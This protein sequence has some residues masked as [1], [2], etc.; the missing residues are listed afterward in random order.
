MHY[1]RLNAETRMD[2][3]PM[4]RVDDI[5]DQVGQAKYL[6]TLDLANGYWQVPVVVEDRPKTAFVTPQG[7]YQFCVMPFG[8]C[9]A[10]AT[11]QRMMD[12]VTQGMGKFTS[13]YLD[14]LIVFSKTWEDHLVH[15][16]TVLS[17]L[18]TLGL[19]ANSSKCQFAMTECIYLGHIVGN[20]VVKPER[21][22]LLAV[23]QFPLP[24]TKTQVRSFLGLLGYYRRFIPNYA[25]IAAPLTDLTR[26]SAPEN[27]SLGIEGVKSFSRLKE[28]M[29]SSAVLR[30]PDFTK[31]FILQ[32][33]ASEVGV[34]ANLS[35]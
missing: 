3:Y 26:K 21:G 24:T 12:H 6:S 29:L 5:L 1:R 20:G 35:Q 10:P 17:R 23:T 31:P 25:T 8:L 15:L 4:P 11:F 18:Q 22:K 34:G 14:D 30:N 33:D 19:T 7:L 27:V 32:T 16:Q 13:A 28:I 2:A 9:G